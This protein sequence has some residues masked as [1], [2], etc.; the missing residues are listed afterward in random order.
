[1]KIFS[2]PLNPKLNPSQFN[3]YLGF[4]AKY[5]D[6]I[7]DIYFTSRIA[8]FNQDAMGD[9]FLMHE[10]DSIQCIEAA[11]YIQQTFNIPASATFNNI[12]VPSDQRYLDLFIKNFRPLY[13]A[14]IRSATIPH[15]QWLLTKQIQTEFPDL[16]IKNTILR[17]VNRANQV[18]VLAEAGFHYVNLDRDL[19]RDRDELVK[20]MQVKKQ[21]PKLKISLLANEGCA[22]NCPIMEEHY[23]Y[24]CSRTQNEPQYFNSSIARISCQKW[25]IE[26]PAIML[27]TANLPPWRD[28][29]LELLDLGIDTFKMHGRESIDRLAE[30]M[31]IIMRFANSDAI[32]FD[33]FEEYTKDTNLVDRPIDGWRTLIKNCKFDCWDCHYCDKIY[34][35]KS[36]E[37]YNAKVLQVVSA[38]AFHDIIPLE[39]TAIAGLTS[40]RVRKLLYS[41]A[42]ISTNYLEIGCYHG[43]TATSVLDADIKSAYFVDHWNED[44]QPANGNVIPLN[45]KQE[46]IANVKKHKKSTTVKLFTCDLFETDTTEITDIDLFFYDGPHDAISTCRAVDY[47]SKCF[48][49]EAILVFDDAN[50]NGVVDGA[51]QGIINAKLNIQ[52]E[53]ILLNSLESKDEWWNGLYI[54]IIRR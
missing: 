25:D 17:K 20:I 28:D 1:M 44:V 48:S 11:L 32:L 50:F 7:Y 24:N 35:K 34:A 10:Q 2:L 8:P 45:D 4:V 42:K 54:V 37:T 6:Y 52:Y 9:V 12:N 51:K 39:K 30:S 27:K 33:N 36:N 31:R 29:W 21:F 5:K 40:E 49:H 15:T 46:F 22:G 41:F 16:F 38:L 23:Q 13:E 43:A 26:D 47:Y 53:K 14:G 18:Y 3:D 19:M